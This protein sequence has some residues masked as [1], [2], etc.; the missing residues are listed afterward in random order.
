MNVLTVK[1]KSAI[2][3]TKIAIKPNNLTSTKSKLFG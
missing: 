2:N 3:N 1:N